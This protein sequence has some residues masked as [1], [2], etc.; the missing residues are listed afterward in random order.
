M[1]SNGVQCYQRH[2]SLLYVVCWTFAWGKISLSSRWLCQLLK[3]CISSAA[4][5]TSTLWGFVWHIRS[6]EVA[7]GPWSRSLFMHMTQFTDVAPTIWHS[8]LHMKS[9]PSGT[10]WKCWKISRLN[11]SNV[12]PFP[13]SVEPSGS[14][15]MKSYIMWFYT[16]LSFLE[17]VWPR[18]HNV[19]R[20]T[21]PLTSVFPALSSVAAALNSLSTACL[22]LTNSEQG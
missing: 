21:K 1:M 14:P 19:T 2:F 20:S 17:S 13:T 8:S 10:K 22:I 3:A 9:H 18:T 4:K 5:M 11:W 16:E 7:V 12:D 6:A 15:Q